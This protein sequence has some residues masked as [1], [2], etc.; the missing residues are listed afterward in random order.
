MLRSI[1]MYSVPSVPS[2]S[3]SQL[4]VTLIENSTALSEHAPEA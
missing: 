1:K 2:V 3:V 4:S